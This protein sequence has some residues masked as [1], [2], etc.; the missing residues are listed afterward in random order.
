MPE[1]SLAPCWNAADARAV[2]VTEALAGDDALF[3]ATHSALRDFRVGGSHASDVTARSEEGLLRALSDREQRHAFCVVQGEPGSGKSHLIRWLAVNWPHADDLCLLI[4]RA[5]GSLDGTLRQ[6]QARLPAEFR[7]L[8]DRMGQQQAAGISG[9]SLN[10]LVTLGASLEPDYFSSPPEDAEWCRI[11]QPGKLILNTQVR[12]NWRGPRRVLDLMGGRRERTS[13]SAEFTLEDVVELA[14]HCPDVHDSPAAEH[15]A[16]QLMREADHL[17]DLRDQGIGWEELRSN[18]E[19]RIRQSLRLVSALNRRRNHAVQNVIGISADGL[20]RLF[21]DLRRALRHQG[22][23]LVLLLEDVTSWQGLDD[24]LVDALVTDAGTRTADD[25]CPLLSVVGV[26][27]EY[28]KDLP[29]NYVQRI[30]HSIHLGED[31]GRLE[32]VASLRDPADRAGFA[33]RYLAAARAGP[34][35]LASWRERF[36]ANH[37][38]APP[39]VC[40]TCE[41]RDTCHPTFGTVGDVGLFP[42]THQ[43]IEGFFSSL[44]VD[45]G[46]MT[47]RTPRGVLQGL[48]N[49]TLLNPAVL[50]AGRYP[51]PEVE[52]SIMDRRSLPNLLVRRI[53]LHVEDPAERQRFRRLLAYWGTGRPEVGRRDDG[54]EAYAGLSRELLSAF[55]LPWIADDVVEATPPPPPTVDTTP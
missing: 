28:F 42:F 7:H 45:D 47:H 1:A 54:H 9:R 4:Q 40:L 24:S 39:N 46:G 6:L 38:L 12:A 41:R 53:D 34:A 21:E 17:R 49:P 19:D 23:R 31:Q 33:A 11:H 2:L 18:G 8:F 44:K 32:D 3:L 35:R 15:L 5:D 48:L 50:E 36:R 26:T 30:T 25:L 13:Q 16:R 10:F 43:A 22:Q 51:G 20:K 52:P 55:G 29:S 37:D 27:S 14:R